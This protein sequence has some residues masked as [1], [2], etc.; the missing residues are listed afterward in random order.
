MSV[1]CQTS[2]SDSAQVFTRKILKRAYKLLFEA[3]VRQ[4]HYLRAHSHLFRSGAQNIEKLCP[5]N[6][7][8]LVQLNFAEKKFSPQKQAWMNGWTDMVSLITLKVSYEVGKESKRKKT[9]A[10][11]AA[12]KLKAAVY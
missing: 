12:N 2:E 11:G 4:A 9:R 8:Q 1:P 3:L 7:D 5:R 6:N 10:D